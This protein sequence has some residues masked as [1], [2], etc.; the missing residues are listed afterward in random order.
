ML[1]FRSAPT[2]PVL[3]LTWDEFEQMVRRGQVAPSDLVRARVITGD[4]WWTAD[5]LA[6]FHRTSLVKHPYGK[7]L[8]A[9]V[10]AKRRRGERDWHERVTDLHYH[11]ARDFEDGLRLLPLPLVVTEPGVLAASRFITRPSFR[12]D[13]IVTCVYVASELHVEVITPSVR[14][15]LPH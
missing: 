4:D 9:E 2:E 11:W 12:R 10:E 3:K 8:A 13:R 6:L 15:F 5:N 7:H 1:E 14:R